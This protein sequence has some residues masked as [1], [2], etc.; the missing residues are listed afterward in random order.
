MCKDS[1]KI[2]WSVIIAVVLGKVSI[3]G[4]T[5]VGSSLVNH[6]LLPDLCMPKIIRREY[7]SGNTVDRFW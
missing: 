5:I 7:R 2:Q 1:N 4:S 3:A 6:S